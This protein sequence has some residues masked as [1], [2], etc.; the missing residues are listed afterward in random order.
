MASS[1]GQLS[2]IPISDS[3]TSLPGQPNLSMEK[4]TSVSGQPDISLDKLTSSPSDLTPHLPVQ[5]S[6]NENLTLES[7]CVS[8][9]NS[10]SSS[11]STP[12]V[13]IKSD[14]STKWCSYHNSRT[15]F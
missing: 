3:R 15:H 1:P 8:Q 7:E 9:S 10:V 14:E 2:P 11:I 13:A 6:L 12:S 5:I 4:T